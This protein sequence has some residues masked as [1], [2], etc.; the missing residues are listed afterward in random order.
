MEGLKLELKK[1]KYNIFDAISIPIRC[2]PISAIIIIFIRVI[3]GLVPLFLINSTAGVVDA[4]K[5]S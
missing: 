3:D 1:K 2:S 5:K 4:V